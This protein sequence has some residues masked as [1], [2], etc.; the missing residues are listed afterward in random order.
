MSELTPTQDAWLRAQRMTATFSDFSAHDLATMPMDEFTRLT[1]R[2]LVTEPP[3]PQ[4]AHPGHDPQA[5]AAAQQPAR[6]V[7]HPGIDFSQLSMSE[8]K[9]VREHLGIGRS[10]STRGIFGN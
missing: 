2:K 9:R 5:V 1:G 6:S 7:E 10:P 4:Q 3:A 8:Y